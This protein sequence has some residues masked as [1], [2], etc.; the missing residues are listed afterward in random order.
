MDGERV[1][2]ENRWNR[3]RVK[4][5]KGGARCKEYRVRGREGEKLKREDNGNRLA[6]SDT[7]TNERKRT[8]YAI[9]R[10][11]KCRRITHLAPQ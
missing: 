5:G 2:E 1:R 4:E 6:V 11:L 9:S 8:T 10:R 7:K 3:G